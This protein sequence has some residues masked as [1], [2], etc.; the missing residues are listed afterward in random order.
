MT[1][2]WRSTM[3]IGDAS[4]DADHQALV[5]LINAVELTL[6]AGNGRAELGV[7]MDQLA[8]YALAHFEREE[9]LMRYTSFNGLVPHRQSHR[10][11]R[12]QLNTIR[13]TIEGET[14]ESLPTKDVA[15]LVDLLRHWL[16][17]H[18]LKEDMQIKA[19]LKKIL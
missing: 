11:L 2:E 19:H 10:E 7:A 12:E 17:D 1:I 5:Q 6:T 15:R 16:L 3:A 13:R 8:S 18:V 4:V 9:N 14:L